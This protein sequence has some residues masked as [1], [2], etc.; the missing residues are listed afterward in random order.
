M[1]IKLDENMPTRLAGALKGMGHDADTVEEEGLS[2]H[3]DPSVWTAAQEDCR[4]FITQDI[5]FTDVRHH[6]PGTH[7]GV[8]LLRLSSNG[9]VT[10][11]DRVVELFTSLDV[12]T[13]EGCNVVV[14]EERVRVRR[15]DGTV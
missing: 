3:E 13:W 9:R 11:Y 5:F 10:A 1:R 7:K 2:G 4:F 15:P 12:T 6:P 8:L 14:D